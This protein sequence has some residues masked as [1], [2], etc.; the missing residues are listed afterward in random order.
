MGYTNWEPIRFDYVVVFK[1][2]K[3]LFYCKCVKTEHKSIDG[4][5][6]LNKKQISAKNTDKVRL[7]A[8]MW[9]VLT[10]QTHTVPTI[11]TPFFTVQSGK[12]WILY[13]LFKTVGWISLYPC[14]HSNEN[15][16]YNLQ[17]GASFEKCSLMEMFSIRDLYFPGRK[18]LTF[19]SQY[20]HPT[21]ILTHTALSMLSRC[22]NTRK[23]GEVKDK[24]CY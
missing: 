12:C 23:R 21:H 18:T 24:E 9:I 7:K 16:I 19:L 15:N 11:K 10:F 17:S 8:F 2:L 13:V 5:F 22:Y 20:P 1:L 3:L 4:G 6:L 14:H